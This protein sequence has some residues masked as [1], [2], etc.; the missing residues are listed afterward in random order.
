MSKRMNAVLTNDV[1]A[2]QNIAIESGFD[3]TIIMFQN[4]MIIDVLERIYK[5]LRK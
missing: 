1:E 4:S 5:E 2:L 3:N